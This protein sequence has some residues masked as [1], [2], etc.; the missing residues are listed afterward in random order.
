MAGPTANKVIA[1]AEAARIW[2]LYGY[3]HP[4]ELVL[5]DLAYAMGVVVVEGPLDASDARLVRKGKRGLVR[6]KETIPEPGRKRFALA[7]ELGHWVMHEKIS[8][9]LACTSEDMVSQYKTSPPEIEASYFASALILPE[10]LFAERIKHSTPTY[11]LL[12]KLA[13][14]FQTSLTATA[15]RYVELSNDY[16][17]LVVSENGRVRWWRHS[18]DFKGNFWI[19]PGSRLSSKTVA[20]SLFNGEGKPARPE[21]VDITAWLPDIDTNAIDSDVIVEE[22]IPILSYNQVLSLLWLP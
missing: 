3:A 8:Q 9:I 5:E 16:C 22:S 21:K 1:Q 6:I 17:A 11:K 14:E 7:H 13:E 15:V 10:A 19:D 2:Q 18:D 20:A 4:R 12:S